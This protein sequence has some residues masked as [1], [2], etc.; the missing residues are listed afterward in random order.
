MD[1]YGTA[2]AKKNASAS[3]QSMVLAISICQLAGEYN[4]AINKQDT[5]DTVLQ[6][7]QL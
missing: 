5:T 4:A 7:S 1:I 2:A 3:R 6:T